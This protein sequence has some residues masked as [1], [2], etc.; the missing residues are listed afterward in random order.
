MSNCNITKNE[1]GVQF[2]GA[3]TEMEMFDSLG[4]QLR[5]TIATACLDY[6]VYQVFWA[7]QRGFNTEEELVAAIMASDEKLLS[8]R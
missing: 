7:K 8:S 3:T 2:L 4:P 1:G 6:S 5:Q